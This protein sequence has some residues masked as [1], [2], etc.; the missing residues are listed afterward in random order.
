MRNVYIYCVESTISFIHMAKQ[1]PKNL[2]LIKKY[3]RDQFAQCP[4]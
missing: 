4:T 1:Q 3:L 2:K